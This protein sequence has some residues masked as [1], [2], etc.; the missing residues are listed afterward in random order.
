M[1]LFYKVNQ[2]TPLVSVHLSYG[3]AFCNSDSRVSPQASGIKLSL[4]RTENL[5]FLTSLI[6]FSKLTKVHKDLCI[7]ES[8]C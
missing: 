4:R 8:K 2:E 6:S 1:L 3:G 7:R 5:S